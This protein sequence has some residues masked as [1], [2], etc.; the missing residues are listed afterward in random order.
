MTLHRG[1]FRIVTGLVARNKNN[2]V[3]FRSALTTSIGIRGTDFTVRACME[4]TVCGALYGV[5]AA[6]K[7]GG[8]SLKN[9]AGIIALNK[10]EFAQV[11]NTTDAPARAPLPG[12]FYDLDFDVSNIEVSS[13]WWQRTLNWFKSYF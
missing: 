8:I 2:R 4:Q 3:D 9:P 13:S 10:N 12:G 7:T 11:K 1:V 6:V 5:S